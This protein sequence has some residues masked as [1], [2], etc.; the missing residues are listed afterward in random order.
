MNVSPAQPGI[1]PTG[2]WLRPRANRKSIIFILAIIVVLV[3]AT[4]FVFRLLAVNS[5]TASLPYCTGFACSLAM[6]NLGQSQP[7]PGVF[8][9]E[10]TVNPTEGLPTGV[11]GLEIRNST[12]GVVPPGIHPLSCTASSGGSFTAFTVGYCGAPTG[13]WYAVLV[14]DNT[15]VATV[16][17]TGGWSGA[18]VTLT[19]LMEIYVISGTSYH[20]VGDSLI[21]Q[22]TGSS[23]I[24]GS[25]VL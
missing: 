22:G 5:S 13:S 12:D 7:A 24:S 25:V 18:E 16:F 4:V 1:H 17:D 23:S 15:T 19:T 10:I 21:A 14:F 2:S 9:I 11:F 6:H 3:I 8:E 20:G